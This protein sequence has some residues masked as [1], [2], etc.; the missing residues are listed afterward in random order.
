M[1]T[2]HRTIHV[3]VSA[4]LQQLD[5]V[6]RLEDGLRDQRGDPDR[7]AVD[8]QVDLQ[9]DSAPIKRRFTLHPWALDLVMLS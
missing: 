7:R 9:G 5:D 3:R 2:V 8:D 1:Q 4:H 6:A